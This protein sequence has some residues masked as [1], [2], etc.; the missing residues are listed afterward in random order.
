[1][2]RPLMEWKQNLSNVKPVNLNLKFRKCILDFRAFTSKNLFEVDG[3]FSFDI[4]LQFTVYKK[5]NFVRIV[6][7]LIS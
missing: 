2:W 4:L 5:R 3:F 1:M 7:V 6:F